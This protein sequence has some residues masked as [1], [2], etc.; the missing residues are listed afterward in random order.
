ML[1]GLVDFAVAGKQTFFVH[2]IFWTFAAAKIQISQRGRKILISQR[3]L[4]R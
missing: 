1:T 4:W 2:L 3:G